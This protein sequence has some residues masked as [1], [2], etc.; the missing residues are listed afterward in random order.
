MEMYSFYIP[1]PSYAEEM[2]PKVSKQ[3]VDCLLLCM[4]PAFFFLINLSVRSDLID[5][6]EANPLTLFIL[7]I[8]TSA[9]VSQLCV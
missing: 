9:V 3:L 2:G 6:Y 7:G 8:I 5:S 4:P 1:I